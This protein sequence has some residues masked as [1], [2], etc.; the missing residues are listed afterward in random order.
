MSRFSRSGLPSPKSY[1]AALRLL[2]ASQLFEDAGLSIADVA[3]RLDYSS[4][5]SFGRHVRSLLGI[6]SSEFRTRF[7]DTK[8]F[9]DPFGGPRFVHYY[10]HAHDERNKQFDKEKASHRLQEA[11]L[12]IEAAHACSLRMSMEKPKSGLLAAAEGKP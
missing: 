11:Q 2:H 12:F 5:Q 6:T 1:L 10:I 8:L 3:H 4:P 9:H 7:H